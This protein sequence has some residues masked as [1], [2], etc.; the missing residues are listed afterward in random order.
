MAGPHN[1]MNSL[2]PIVVSSRRAAVRH[3]PL[4]PGPDF[5]TSVNSKVPCT[6]KHE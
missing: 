6:T 2:S 3:T 5:L 4:P 1:Q